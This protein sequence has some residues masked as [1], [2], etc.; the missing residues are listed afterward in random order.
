MMNKLFDFLIIQTLIDVYYIVL[1]LI[2]GYYMY[3]IFN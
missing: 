2:V 3:V 1:G